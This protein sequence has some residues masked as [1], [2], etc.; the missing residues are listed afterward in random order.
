[1]K[2]YDNERITNI[3]HVIEKIIKSIQ[4]VEYS[5]E[6]YVR[7]IFKYSGFYDEHTLRKI[8]K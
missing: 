3:N 6:I 2:S 4:N 1:M 7:I 5:R 8:L